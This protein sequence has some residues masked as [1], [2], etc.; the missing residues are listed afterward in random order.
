[1]ATSRAAATDA[2]I[3]WEP[4]PPAIP[5]T[6]APRSIAS[7]ASSRRSSPG[8]RTTGSMPRSMHAPTSPKRSAFPP[9]ERGLINRTGRRAGAT[10]APAVGS[11]LSVRTSRPRAQRPS[12]AATTSSATPTTARTKLVRSPS[13]ATITIPIKAATLRAAPTDRRHPARVNAYHI[14]KTASASNGA[15]ARSRMSSGPS[16]IS[17]AATPMAVDTTAPTAAARRRPSGGDFVSP[18]RSPVKFLLTHRRGSCKY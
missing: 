16:P 8:A 10:G 18:I 4:S 11:A 2:T 12:A 14:A 3:A 15:L 17:S 9:P 5:I 1:M 7:S 13:T 6:S